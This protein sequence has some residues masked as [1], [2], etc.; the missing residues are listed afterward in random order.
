MPYL[1]PKLQA[2]RETDRRKEIADRSF[3]ILTNT[4]IQIPKQKP[5]GVNV[6]GLTIKQKRELAKFS[7]EEYGLMCE[8]VA[9]RRMTARLLEID[10]EKLTNIC[11]SANSVKKQIVSSSATQ[12]DKRR[13][14]T[15]PIQ[16]VIPMF[17]KEISARPAKARTII[18]KLPRDLIL[19]IK[20]EFKSLLK[21]E[22]REWGTC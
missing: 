13:A 3:N 10:V 5:I 14:N 20:N 1:S 9:I 8:N 18:D 16:N 7:L 6:E 19:N 15:L 4:P 17:I 2:L 11:K 21:Y 22:L 12:K